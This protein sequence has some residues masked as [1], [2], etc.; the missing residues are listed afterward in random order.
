[1][2]KRF[3]TYSLG[4]YKIIESA[5]RASFK[6]GLWEWD[7]NA[8]IQLGYQKCSISATIRKMGNKEVTTELVI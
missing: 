4:A 7:Q 3:D 1:M 5:V 6:P 2:R 8:T